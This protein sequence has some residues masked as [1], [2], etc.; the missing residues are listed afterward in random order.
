MYGNYIVFLRIPY[1]SIHELKIRRVTMYGLPRSSLIINYKLIMDYTSS[2]ATS[3][4][5]QKRAKPSKPHYGCQATVQDRM[6]RGIT[7]KLSNVRSIM[8][9]FVGLPI[10]E[11]STRIRLST[12]G[13][14]DPP[15]INRNLKHILC[16]TCI[17]LPN[18]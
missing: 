7:L 12:C 9:C 16:L 17:L 8:S 3:I 2:K 4:L 15:H 1:R 10:H 14:S 11:E 6:R 13:C 5:C 18:T